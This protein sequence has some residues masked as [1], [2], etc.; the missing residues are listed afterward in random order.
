MMICMFTRIQL[1]LAN[2]FQKFPNMCPEIYE[3]DPARFLTAIGLAWQSF[4]KKNQIK[5]DFLTGIDMLLMVERGIRGEM[6][7]SI[8]QYGK[9][10]TKNMKDYDKIIVIYSILGSK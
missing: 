10:N 1:L 4:L 6:S 2:V 9:A 8:Y 7:H 5:L 3:R